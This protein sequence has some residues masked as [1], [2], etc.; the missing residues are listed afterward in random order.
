VV[1]DAGAVAEHVSS[2]REVVLM[3]LAVGSVARLVE[4]A[5][6]AT[7]GPWE[8]VEPRPYSWYIVN[9]EQGIHVGT[10]TGETAEYIAAVS[11]DAVVPL[12]EDW[13]R[14]REALLHLTEDV[15]AALEEGTLPH[16]DYIDA[17]IAD[18]ELALDLKEEPAQATEGER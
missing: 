6:A 13:T 4:L 3:P 18:C 15:K 12:A 17:R 10:G 8:V 2:L 7:P 14:M 11:P 5:E 9:A 1:V 16:S